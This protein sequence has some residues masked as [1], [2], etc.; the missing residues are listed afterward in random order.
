MI[1]SQTPQARGLTARWSLGLLC[2]GALVFGAAC[3]SSVSHSGDGGVDDPNTKPNPDVGGG[4][5]GGGGDVI[6][7]AQ[8]EMPT[9]TPAASE[10]RINETKR[11]QT[12]DGVGTNA[13]AYPIVGDFNY[14]WNAVKGV[15][16]EL[17]MEYV[18]LASW[19]EFWEPNN[20]NDDPRSTNMGAFDPSGIIKN[21]DVAFAKYLTGLD[22][23]VELGVWQTGNWLASGSPRTVRN[24]PELGESIAS[25]LTN[26]EN[27]G[28]PMSITEVQNEPGIAA[29]IRYT[30]PEALVEAGLA[31]LDGLDAAG[32]TDVQLHGPNYHAPDAESA[33][34]AEVW[35]ANERL[36]ERTAALS[37]H[38]WWRDDFES[39]DRLRKIAEKHDK[40]VW[41]T[42]VGFCALP[43]GCGNG[44]YLLPET[45]ETA[46]DYAM[47]Y[48]RAL[49]WSHASRL[50]HWTVVGFDASV[51]P[52]TGARYPSFYALK[53]FSNYIEP[54]ARMLDVASGDKDVLVV[55]F[56]LPSGERTAVLLNQSGSS[57]TM[58]LASVAGSE[59]S[60]TQAVTTTRGSYE[61]KSKVEQAEGV[62]RITLP[63]NS[64]TSVRFAP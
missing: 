4:P 31:I 37:Y 52:S 57:K 13:Y 10:V 39:Y 44:H 25:Y 62:A 14:N 20:D 3:N 46:W 56:L 26:M 1:Q 42:E 6:P 64:M 21:H 15:F 32:H 2:A 23:D 53:H 5:G 59:V 24:Y 19:F 38:T 54:G 63:A 12:L 48:Y 41:A 28:V 61:A 60:V 58:D 45:W 7:D 17:D 36:S 11:Y 29:A 50:Y 30:S 33:R 18:R 51:N 55:A 34:W 22:I 9:G 43:A 40:P 8:E 35:F 27:N 16:E 47:S 49:A